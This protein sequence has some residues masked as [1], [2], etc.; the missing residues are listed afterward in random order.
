M[1]NIGDYVK[2]NNT[3]LTGYIVKLIKK[4]YYLININ[5]K[6]VLVNASIVS[7]LEGGKTKNTRK[8]NVTVTIT[9]SSKEF[10]NELMIRHQTLDE[11]LINIEQYISDAIYNNCKQI[12][13]IHGKHGGILRKAV[14]DYLK[15]SPYVKDFRLGDY[16]EGSYGVTVVNL[17]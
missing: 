11:A 3:N 5:D 6:D 16:F 4:D 1:L 2:V 10:C 7:K 15:S 14:H 17:K 13:I 9:K 8:N 12:K